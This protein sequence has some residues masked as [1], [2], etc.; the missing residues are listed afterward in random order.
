LIGYI[1]PSPKGSALWVIDP[2]GKNSQARLFGVLRFDWYLDSRRVVFTR[3]DPD[4]RGPVEMVAVNLETGE[5]AILVKGPSAE[6][7]SAP[8]GRA[9]LYCYAPSHFDMQLNVLRL[10]PPATPAGLPRA[11]GAPQPLTL[12]TGPSHV[13]TGGW[14]PD[15]KWIVATRDVDQGDLYVIQNY[16]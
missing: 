6:L 3:Q 10:T 9:I 1:A 16:R 5:Q 14:S 11:V 13:H 2:Q 4:R 12:P 15:G 7:V 8:G